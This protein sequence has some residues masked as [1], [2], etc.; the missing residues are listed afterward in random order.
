[1]H[2]TYV[3]ITEH[4][5]HLRHHTLSRAVPH[6]LN[7]FLN[8]HTTFS[9]V[10]IYVYIVLLRYIEIKWRCETAG[11]L[12]KMHSLQFCGW[13]LRIRPLK[14]LCSKLCWCHSKCLAQVVEIAPTL[15]KLPIYL[16]KWILR[17]L[18]TWWY[19]D[20]VHQPTCHWTSDL[21]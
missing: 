19:E 8:M 1:M 9:Q 3:H 21:A 11:L 12:H 5:Q 2:K 16:K 15:G 18:M 17:V 7:D 20:S 10:Y 13:Y 4:L 6:T 14:P